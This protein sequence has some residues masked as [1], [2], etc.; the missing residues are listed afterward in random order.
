LLAAAAAASADSCRVR[1]FISRD[2]WTSSSQS[3]HASSLVPA[4]RF[5]ASE[6]MAVT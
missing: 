5:I 6:K 1:M 4:S 2:R 3:R